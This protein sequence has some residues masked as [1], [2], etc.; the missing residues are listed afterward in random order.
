METIDDLISLHISKP[1]RAIRAGKMMNELRERM[2]MDQVAVNIAEDY[3]EEE[4]AGAQKWLGDTGFYVYDHEG[5]PLAVCAHWRPHRH[6]L[7]APQVG[8][9]LRRR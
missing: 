6:H 8:Q 2:G 3:T 4:Y 1:V 7:A 5:L 9:G